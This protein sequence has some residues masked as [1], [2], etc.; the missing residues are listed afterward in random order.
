LIF[1]RPEHEPRLLLNN[2]LLQIVLKYVQLVQETVTQ[3][4]ALLFII[5][6]E[7]V[8]IKRLIEVV[9]E[10]GFFIEPVI[11]LLVDFYCLVIDKIRADPV[12]L[13]E[14]GVEL[15]QILRFIKVEMLTQGSMLTRTMTVLLAKVLK[16]IR[17]GRNR[18]N[19][20]GIDK[21]LHLEPGLMTVET[22][23]FIYG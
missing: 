8:L 1:H 3:I 14:F 23:L 6:V 20:L 17:I 16:L 10:V 18:Y 19:I 11:K 7:N 9:L 21:A 15:G 5:L 13:L 12:D 22:D 2:R 4:P